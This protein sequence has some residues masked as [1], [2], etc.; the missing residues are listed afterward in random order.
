MGFGDELMGSGLARGA[1]SRGK[2]IAFGDGNRIIWHKNAHAIL[3]GN[4]NVAEPGSEGASD[5]QWVTHYPGARAYARMVQRVWKFEPEFRAAPGEVTLSDDERRFADMVRRGFVLI[6]PNVKRVA[7]NKQWPRERYQAVADHL[8]ARGHRV[9]QF[10]T[11]EFRL[12]GINYLTAPT[13][14]DAMA[15]IER[16]ALYIGPEGGLH[17]SAAAMATQAVVIFGGFNSPELFG[18]AGHTSIFSGDGLGCG[19][20]DPCKHCRHCMGMI[21]ADQVIAAAEERLAIGAT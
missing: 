4:P 14:R 18:Y 8:K 12:E 17:H 6:E 9:L 10:D 16:A 7:P 19:R 11:G 15:L 5:L 21:S 2:R 20:Q 13:F 1:A 3:A